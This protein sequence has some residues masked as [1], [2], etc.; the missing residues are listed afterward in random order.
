MKQAGYVLQRVNKES[1][2]ERLAKRQTQSGTNRAGAKIRVQKE[3]SLRPGWQAD[4][5]MR[6]TRGSKHQVV[7]IRE[8]GNEAEQ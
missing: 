8:A 4:A 2:Q 6:Q 1:R 3:A 7:G 5:R